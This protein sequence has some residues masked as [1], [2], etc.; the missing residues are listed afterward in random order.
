MTLPFRKYS[1]DPN[2]VGYPI[3]YIVEGECVC[4]DCCNEAWESGDEYY[5]PIDHPARNNDVY[6]E[7][8]TEAVNWEN[9][10]LWCAYC[11]TQ[12]ESAYASDEENEELS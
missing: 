6:N 8:I 7:E 10:N 4:G 12:I 3:F 5:Q 1:N 2:F 9:Q 11:S